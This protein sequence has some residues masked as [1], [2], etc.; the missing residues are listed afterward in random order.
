[1]IL[2]YIAGPY[3][4][5]DP[6]MNTKLA[7]EAFHRILDAGHA[8]YCPHLSHFADQQTPRPYED[9]MA[10]DFE[11]IQRCD[12]VLRLPGDSTGADREVAFAQQHNIPA[13]LPE[14][15]TLDE[16]LAALS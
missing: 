5:P 1:M 4:S 2:V 7:V 3:T 12:M 16:F 8:A 13:W 6:V 11:I 15:G 9:W 10:L 14:F